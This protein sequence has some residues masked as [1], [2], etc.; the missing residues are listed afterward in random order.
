M[1][2][3]VSII[4]PTYNR[5][6]LIGE[7][8]DSILDQTYENWECIVVDDGSTDKTAA[9][10]AKY[11]GKDKRFRY[12]N[13]IYKKGGQGARNTGIL[14][15]KGDFIIFLDSDDLLAKTC[16]EK[17]IYYFNNYKDQDFL[18]FQCN[19]FFDKTEDSNLVA[20]YLIKKKDDISRFI[21]YD[22]PWHT[23]SAI[24]K[25]EFLLT[26][27]IS[28]SENLEIHQDLD[29]YIKI[30]LYN[31]R[32]LKIIDIPDFFFRMKGPD[33]LSFNKVSPTIINSKYLF[34]NNV[35]SLLYKYKLHKKYKKELYG[36]ALSHMSLFHQH[37]Q[38]ISYFKVPFLF[39]RYKFYF[40]GIFLVLDHSYL[41]LR[42]TFSNRLIRKILKLYTFTNYKER[43]KYVHP[44]CSTLGKVTVS[45]H[46]NNRN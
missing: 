27:K 10:V 43:T 39:F 37:S 7:T 32:Y 11:I 2:S 5:V 4:I 18:I 29:F 12:F 36:L 6:N 16:V 46:L 1:K 45:Q 26:N 3:V 19:L 28:W 17:R 33:K 15:S 25:K 24:L 22:Y 21:S 13:N 44:K 14:H 38:I 23:S 9:L 8:L 40:Q 41:V 34:L 20:N 42:R 30:L 35:I 31:P